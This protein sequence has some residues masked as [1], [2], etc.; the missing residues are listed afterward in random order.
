MVP[1]VAMIVRTIARTA[2]DR[3]GEGWMSLAKLALCSNKLSKSSVRR[4][5]HDLQQLGALERVKVLGA[6][7][8][9]QGYRLNFKSSIDWDPNVECW[10]DYVR[11]IAKG[12]NDRNKR[13]DETRTEFVTR[14]TKEFGPPQTS[15]S[16]RRRPQ[17]RFGY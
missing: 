1:S 13:P 14:I 17:H 5:I 4:A 10:R 16:R 8:I 15:S 9:R 3:T 7:K 12:R 2:N 6:S 11:R